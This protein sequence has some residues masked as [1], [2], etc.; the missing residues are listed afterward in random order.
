[1][2]KVLLVDDEHFIVQGLLVL[3][4]W[5]AEGYEVAATASNGLEALEYLKTNTVDLVITDIA[6]PGMNGLELLETVRREQISEA[7]F[8]ILSGYSDFAYAQQAL[9]GGCMDYLLKPVGREELLAILRR[10]NHLS[11][12]TKQE[13]QDHE[14]FE[15]AYLARNIIALLFGKHDEFNLDY[16]KKRMQL[17]EGVRYIEIEFFGSQDVDAEEGELRELQRKLYQNCRKLLKED[18]AHCVYDVSQ[19]RVSFGVGFL[20]CD[21][22]A[23]RAGCTEREYLQELC[24]KL[25]VLMQRDIRMLV[26][27]KVPDIRQVS[28][29]Y[30]T[31]CILRPLEA[32]HSG[33]PICVYEDE[34]QVKQG[35]I[36]LCV[37]SLDALFNAIEQNEPESIRKNVDRLFLEMQQSGLERDSVNLNINYLL[38]RLVHLASELDSEADQEEIL[39]FISS[40]AFDGVSRGGRQHLAMFACA[41][42]DYLTQLRQNISSGVLAEIEKE[43]RRNYRENLTL[44]ELGKKYYINSSYLGQIFR[45]KYGQSFK[46]YL[47]NYRIGEAVKLLLNTDK[48]ISE[49][50][51]E[52][53]YK[54]GDYFI[55]KF[56]EQKGC[57]PSRFRKNAIA[58]DDG[59]IRYL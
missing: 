1:M 5:E 2:L 22:M 50:A 12:N 58:A 10:Y 28:A 56:I 33:K 49:I 36:V 31:A 29:S 37:E 51:E 16:V 44:R 6:M 8:V 13:R 26:G 18:S 57:T 7:G 53:G 55:R 27:K 23:A 48:R 45:K 19:D 39:R 25:E 38:F 42:A 52:V 35:G 40:G 4:D 17:S 20:Y 34:A 54:D 30:G 14:R 43:I 9:R 11:E 3:I 21:Y 24:R 46:D 47:S 41:Y 15:E 32:F 59:E